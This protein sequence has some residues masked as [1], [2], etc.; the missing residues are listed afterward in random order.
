MPRP[1]S[2]NGSPVFWTAF[3]SGEQRARSPEVETP[4]RK[5]DPMSE[6]VKTELVDGV[7]VL[8]LQRPDK[9][10]ALTGAMYDALSDG[11]ERAEADG[12]IKV[13]LFQGDGDS[14]TAGNDL[15]DFAAQAKSNSDKESPGLSLHPKP[16][17]GHK[18]ADRS[19]A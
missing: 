5:D 1:S 9:K 15:A 12:T 13:V 14:F 10:N 16:R 6:H 8:T 7:L 4:S 2:A 3:R 18:A 17:Q 11:L 19:C